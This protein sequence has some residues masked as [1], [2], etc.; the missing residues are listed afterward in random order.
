MV[1]LSKHGKSQ[2][3]VANKSETGQLLFVLFKGRN[4]IIRL[5]KPTF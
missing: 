1:R 4:G 5:G 3:S 2:V